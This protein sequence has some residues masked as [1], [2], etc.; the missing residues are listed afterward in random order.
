[1]ADLTIMRGEMRN[2]KR[3]NYQTG[4]KNLK[5]SPILL[6]SVS[7]AVLAS[8]MQTYA[9][10][11]TF[12]ETIPNIDYEIEGQTY[13]GNFTDA[14]LKSGSTVFNNTQETITGAMIALTISNDK[15]LPVTLT[16]DGISANLTPENSP[17]TLDFTL[18]TAQY[19]YIQAE[20][21]TFP[22][23]VV[24]DCELDSAELTVYTSSSPQTGVPDGGST[25]MLLGGV[26]SAFGWMRRK[27]A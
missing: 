17:Q 18:T 5:I 24:V 3:S 21:A 10:G 22:Y 11:L 13:H 14:N 16:V 2:A 23:Q 19:D 1:M 4:E 8:G 9:A 25:V 7:L 26:V 12:T 27:K 6:S 15:G 20:D